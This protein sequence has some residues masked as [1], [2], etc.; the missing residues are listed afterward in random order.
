[1]FNIYKMKL[2]EVGIIIGYVIVILAFFYVLGLAL[3]TKNIVENFENRDESLSPDRLAE[4]MEDLNTS[5]K[6][7]LNIGK[8][9]AA[10]QDA[11]SQVHEHIN[12]NMLQTMANTKSALPEDDEMDRVLKL[13]QYRDV[14]GEME[15]FLDSVRD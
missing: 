12:L 5:L 7:D 2:R 4:L 1:M 13:R 14:A 8:N 9:R 6:D 3:N 10:Y 15:D 11:L